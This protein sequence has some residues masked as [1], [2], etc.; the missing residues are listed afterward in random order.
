[1]KCLFPRLEGSLVLVLKPQL[2]DNVLRITQCALQ[3]LEVLPDEHNL[4]P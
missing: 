1:M 2:L 3:L 4:L